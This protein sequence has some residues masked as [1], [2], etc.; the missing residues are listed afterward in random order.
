LA[1]ASCAEQMIR[2]D[3]LRQQFAN[4]Q[5]SQR[6]EPAQTRAHSFAPLN[7]WALREV[8]ETTEEFLRVLRSGPG[9]HPHSPEGAAP[10]RG[11]LARLFFDREA[12]EVPSDSGRTSPQPPARP[13]RSVF[14]ISF[15]SAGSLSAKSLILWR[16]LGDRENRGSTSSLP[17]S[18]DGIAILNRNGFFRSGKSAKSITPSSPWI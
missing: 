15:R 5:F 17:I 13:K 11:S 14:S 7:F 12:T 9:D 18:P 1:F 3:D 6:H 10:P 4:N 8:M 2:E 16:S